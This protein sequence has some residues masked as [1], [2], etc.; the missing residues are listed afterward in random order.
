MRVKSALHPKIR[1]MCGLLRTHRHNGSQVSPVIVLDSQPRRKENISRRRASSPAVFLHRFPED[2]ERKKRRKENSKS[3]KSLIRLV[4]EAIFL[5][6]EKI[7]FW[8]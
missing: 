5:L 4:F 2:A 7:R 1:N 8:N 3:F 6:L